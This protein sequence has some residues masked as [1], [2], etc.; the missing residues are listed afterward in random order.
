[1]KAQDLLI[2]G[3]GTRIEIKIV[4]DSTEGIKYLRLDAG[5]TDTF[6]IKHSAISYTSTLKDHKEFFCNGYKS[7]YSQSGINSLDADRPDTLNSFW[8][9]LEGGSSN[10]G[11]IFGLSA[12]YL[13]DKYLFSLEYLTLPGTTSDAYTS[14][15]PN[16]NASYPTNINVETK[17]NTSFSYYEARFG[18]T[19][20]LGSKHY[21]S[22]DLSSGL[23]LKRISTTTAITTTTS[24]FNGNFT[25][26][27]FL[28]WSGYA[29]NY[30]TSSFSSSSTVVQNFIGLPLDIMFHI[31]TTTALGLDLGF[32][33]DLNTQQSLFAWTIGLRIGRIV[34]RHHYYTNM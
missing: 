26:T 32:K 22:V 9:N 18:T 19:Y 30:N 8:V 1:M 7:E 27:T 2:L 4:K 14:S 31:P 24:V 28:F 21:F 5:K 33:A 6:Y 17:I 10:V 29:A 3:D 13:Y 34:N 12:N 23:S 11:A 15:S 20:Y 25:Y 16:P